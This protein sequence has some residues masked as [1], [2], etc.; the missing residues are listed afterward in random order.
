MGLS[1]N[2]A[3]ILNSVKEDFH[4]DAEDSVI[5]I[6]AVLEVFVEFGAAEEAARRIDRSAHK[7]RSW[8]KGEGGMRVTSGWKAFQVV[9]AD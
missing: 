3:T 8:R 4:A 7:K 9:S 1:P 6:E 2:S 5:E